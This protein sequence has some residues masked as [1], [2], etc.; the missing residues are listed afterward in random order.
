MAEV[1]EFFHTKIGFTRID[2]TKETYTSEKTIIVSG[3]DKIDSNCDFIDRSI[4][5]EFRQPVLYSIALDRPLSR[6]KLEISKIKL[7]KIKKYVC[8]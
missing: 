1:Q 7:H 3:I 8:E 5:T 4:V 6:K 2:Y